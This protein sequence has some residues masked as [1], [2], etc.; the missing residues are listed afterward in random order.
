MSAAPETDPPNAQAGPQ[1]ATFLFADI[2][3]FTA[4]IEAHG[5]EQAAWLVGEFCRAVQAELPAS[6]GT[7]VKSIGDAIMLRPSPSR[8]RPSRW[9]C[10]SP[11][12][13]SASTAPPPSAWACITA[14]RLNATATTSA[15]P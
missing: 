4:L 6:G 15:R 14:R 5:D 1:Q 10:V 7:Q 9:G 11:P 13:C 8:A 3:G 2:A 12:S